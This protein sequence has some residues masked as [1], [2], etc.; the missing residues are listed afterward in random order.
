ML[1]QSGDIARLGLLASAAIVLFV[2]ESLAPR[3]LPWMKLG[4]G[5]LPVLV[6]LLCFGSGPA[7][8]VIVIKLVVGGL[9]SGSFAG[10]A[11]VIGGGAGLASWLVM[12]VVRR[13]GGKL[14][15]VVGLSIWGAL[16]HQLVQ[17]VLA[18]AYI[19]Q[20]GLFALLPLSLFSALLSGGLIGLLAW[21]TLDQLGK[22]GW[23]DR[24]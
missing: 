7:L 8:A 20:F 6:S 19:G 11:F 2:F 15:S 14:F 21:W 23:L 10:P 24:A 16:V 5:N 3:P 1:R 18:Y 9:L 22:I 17:L 12:V 4:L 13:I